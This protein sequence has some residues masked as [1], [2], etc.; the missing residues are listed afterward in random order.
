MRDGVQCFSLFFLPL[1]VLS[2]HVWI[3]GVCRIMKP[4]VYGH[5]NPANPIMQ[6][7][8]C[9]CFSA[10]TQQEASD[11]SIPTISLGPPH[12]AWY[13]QLYKSSYY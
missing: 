10:I 13:G 2:K 3:A 7:S 6:T 9:R 11:V 4:L 8:E 1:A 12:I 5:H